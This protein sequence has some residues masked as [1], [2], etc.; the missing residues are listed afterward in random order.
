MMKATTMSGARRDFISTTLSY[1]RS[2]S[3]CV[4]VCIYTK[5][6]WRDVPHTTVG[7]CACTCK[8]KWH[9][10]PNMTFPHLLQGEGAC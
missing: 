3:C 4:V 2:C 9:G 5:W 1:N 7:V 6:K 8:W 10:M